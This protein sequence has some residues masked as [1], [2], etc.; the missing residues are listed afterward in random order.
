MVELSVGTIILRVYI[1]V[2]VLRAHGDGDRVA[3]NENVFESLDS[4]CV[5]V[6]LLILRAQKS[7]V[8]SL[9]WDLIC[10]P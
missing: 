9:A 8:E 3:A 7:S 6:E 1:A 5:D 4:G 10:L 2:L